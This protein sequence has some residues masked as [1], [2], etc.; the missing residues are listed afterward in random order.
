MND[1]SFVCPNK[2]TLPRSQRIADKT[3]E[4]YR[5]DIIREFRSGGGKG[6]AQALRWIK[7]KG[8]PGF[9]PRFVKPSLPFGI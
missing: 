1:I 6:F 2:R 7:H 3:W 9:D 4:L 8:I 5:A